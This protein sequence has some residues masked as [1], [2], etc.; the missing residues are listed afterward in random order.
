MIHAN[1]FYEF[2]EFRKILAKRLTKRRILLNRV[3]NGLCWIFFV[4]SK[5]H[6]GELHE[7]EKKFCNF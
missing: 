6:A 1:K 2:R 5:M 7:L 4:L 3:T